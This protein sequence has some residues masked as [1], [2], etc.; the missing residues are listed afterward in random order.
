MVRTVS[1]IRG[2]AG[3]LVAAVA[4]AAAAALP[5]GA[6]APDFTVPA[7]LAGKAYRYSLARSLERGPVVL[8]FYPKAFTSGCTAEAH[9]FAE[10]TPRFNALGASVLGMSTDDLGTLERFSVEGCRDK[11][12]V[13]ADEGG[14]IARRYDAVRPGAASMADRV[15]YVIGPHGRVLFV[16]SSSDPDEHVRRT[17]A[18]VERWKANAPGPG[19]GDQA[20]APNR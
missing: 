12:A 18:T 8:Y 2:M 1:A 10:A 19:T 6:S 7:A 11:F 20:R 16:Y 17:L 3:A 9:E 4:T 14:R 13:A 15:S 5:V